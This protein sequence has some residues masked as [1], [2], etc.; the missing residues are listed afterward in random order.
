MKNIMM[1]LFVMIFGIFFIACDEDK[2]DEVK[3]SDENPVTCEV[4]C[5]E[6]QECK[7]VDEKPTCVVK[8]E[9]DKDVVT[10]GNGEGKKEEVKD[11]EKENPSIQEPTDKEDKKD[12]EVKDPAGDKEVKC[13]P[14][15]KEDQECKLVEE[16]SVC[17]DK[18][19]EETKPAEEVKCE[20][21]CAEDMEC[22]EGKCVK[23]DEPASEENK[24]VE[25]TDK[26]EDDKPSTPEEGK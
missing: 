10:E 22:K 6:D 13:D 9:A 14:V 5:A 12:E 3:P 4:P 7:L 1:F 2:K 24:P 19:A 15:C 21:L 11:E 17:V 25:D 26:K 20:V 8:V 18:P 23:K 16:K